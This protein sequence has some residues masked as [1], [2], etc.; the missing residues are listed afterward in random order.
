MGRTGE[1]D[2]AQTRTSRRI[3]KRNRRGTNG[4]SRQARST[5]G[6]NRGPRTFIDVD[7][8]RGHPLVENLVQ[9]QAGDSPPRARPQRP[10]ALLLQIASYAAAIPGI[11]PDLLAAMLWAVFAAIGTLEVARAPHDGARQ[12]RSYQAR[13]RDHLRPFSPGQGKH[14]RQSS[15]VEPRRLVL[16]HLRAGR[17]SSSNCKIGTWVRE[18]LRVASPWMV[19]K[20]SRLAWFWSPPIKRQLGES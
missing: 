18:Q 3:E 4:W 17:P 20:L 16:R 9:R 11:A 6:S 12:H 14:R 7:R 15:G 8:R 2:G 5:D 19:D 13:G 10:Q 1:S